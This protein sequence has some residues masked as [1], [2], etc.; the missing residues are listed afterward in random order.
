[1]TACCDD[2]EA[3]CRPSDVVSES[4]ADRLFAC[5]GGGVCMPAAYMGKGFQPKSCES[6]AGAEGACVSVCV[7]SVKVLANLLPQDICADDE[8]C[9]PCIDPTD[10][11]P[12]G[13]CEEIVCEEAEVAPPTPDEPAGDPCDGDAPQV[14]DPT[15]FPECCPGAH[16]VPQ[17][18]VPPEQSA[19]LDKCGDQSSGYCVPGKLIA[20]GGLYKPPTCVSIGGSEGRCMSTCIPGIAEKAKDLPLDICSAG[21]VCAPCCDPFTGESTGACS[22]SKC[23]TGPAN[24]VCGEVLFKP[25]CGGAVEGHCI[26]PDAIPADKHGNL[27]EC[28][29]GLLCVPD[30]MQD[31]SYKGSPCYGNILFIGDYFGVCLPDCLKLPAE[32]MLDKSGCGP[33]YVCAPYKDP[34]FGSPT[35]APGCG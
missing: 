19:L 15:I 18:L 4:L 35:G 23:D 33:G 25:C 31:L 8:R 27:E 9:A 28:D 20:S 1:M 21:E 3:Y 5:A 7:K 26:A 22:A 32:F 14:I 34:F 6:I 24:G 30:E 2:G 16:C 13:A 29:G 17:G 12:S 10:N 11:T